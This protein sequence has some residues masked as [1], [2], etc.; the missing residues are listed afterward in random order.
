MN[1]YVIIVSILIGIVVGFLTGEW[2]IKKDIPPPFPPVID[3]LYV[4]TPAVPETVRVKA[5]ITHVI[6]DTVFADS[7]LMLSDSV[8]TAT[9]TFE[10]YGK[11]DVSYFFPP[12]NEFLLKF[13]PFP[14]VET[15]ITKTIYVPQ[16]IERIS[17]YNDPWLNRGVGFTFGI[18]AAIL[19]HRGL[20]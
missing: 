17:W 5:I 2:W 1:K 16:Y 18:G 8:A 14:K 9:K 6:R 11:L 13:D 20:K 7:G 15:I 4:T 12:Q 10:G 3:T 19:I